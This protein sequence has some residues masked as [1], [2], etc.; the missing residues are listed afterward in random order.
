MAYLKEK[1]ESKF[2]AYLPFVRHFMC[3]FIPSLHYACEVTYIPILQM[4]EETKA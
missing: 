2:I 3:Y 1:N 4:K